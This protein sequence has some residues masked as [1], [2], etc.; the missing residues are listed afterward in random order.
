MR[1]GTETET[2]PFPIPRC[3][4]VYTVKRYAVKKFTIL[5]SPGI[6]KKKRPRLREQ[7]RKRRRKKEAEGHRPLRRRGFVPDNDEEK[8]KDC[9]KAEGSAEVRHPRSS[10]FFFRWLVANKRKPPLSQLIFHG[11]DRRQIATGR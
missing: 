5:S 7:T 9:Q 2:P 6:A 1:K 11:A 10:P 8:R 4:S 3:T